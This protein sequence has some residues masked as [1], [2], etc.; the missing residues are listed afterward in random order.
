MLKLE[1]ISSFFL[2]QSQNYLVESNKYKP[3]RVLYLLTG[4]G[5]FGGSA[6]PGKRGGGPAIL[7][8]INRR[9]NFYKG[10]FSGNRMRVK[11]I[12]DYTLNGGLL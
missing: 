3:I 2:G 10:V 6:F 12:P 7:Y 11:S 5:E 9:A 1:L 4:K 8:P